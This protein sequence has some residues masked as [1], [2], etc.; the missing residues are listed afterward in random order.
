MAVTS[1]ILQSLSTY[2]VEEIGQRLYSQTSPL[3]D[4]IHEHLPNLE[5]FEHWIDALV[6]VPI[7]GIIVMWASG[8]DFDYKECVRTLAVVFIIRAFTNFVTILPCP[9]LGG[10]YKSFGG[11]YT[12]IFSGH[13]ATIMVLLYFIGLEIPF[14]R[15]FELAYILPS[16]LFIVASRT[17]Y[18]IDVIVAAFVVLL[19][20]HHLS[21]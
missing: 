11:S 3:Y 7:I 19:V 15:T 13:L 4:V 2:H 17:H 1:A 8:I 14:V 12:C 10:D 20:Q 18:T 21:L 16:A 9:K 6:I 5:R